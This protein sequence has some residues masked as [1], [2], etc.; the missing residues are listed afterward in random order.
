MAGAAHLV[1]VEGAVPLHPE[2]TVFE[3]ML[4]GWAAQQGSRRLAASTIGDRLRLVRRFASFTNDY[5]WRWRPADVEDWTVSLLSAPRPAAYSTVR[6]Y[7]QALAMFCAYV[8]DRR[9]GWARV[10]EERFGALPVQVCHEWNTVVHASEY[11]GRPGN[12]PLARE[13]LQAFFDHADEQV[14]RVRRLGRKGWLAAFRDATLF[15]V[16]YAWGLRRREGAKLDLVDF[17]RNPAA[18]EFGEVGMLSVRFG[19]AAKGGPPRR[20]NVLTVMPWAAEAVAEYVTEIRPRYGDRHP[21]LWPTERGGRVS[22]DYVSARF[23]EYRDALGLPSELGPHCLRHSY[24][25][26]LVEDGFDPLFV[27][28]QV[29]HAWGSTTALY[30]GVSS[31]F[32]NRVLRAALERAFGEETTSEGRTR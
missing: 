11:E 7:Q 32:K 23:G 9:Y 4:E 20:R 28:Q 26:H 8:T 16:V 5:P 17:G 2:E 31:D 12:R 6:T 27:Q 3:A 24:V 13:E 25:T 15:K 22:P 10:C 14:A 19:K 1:L 18:P 21:A 29:G 30:T